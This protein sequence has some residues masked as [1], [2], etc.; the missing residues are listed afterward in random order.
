MLPRL[1]P[2]VAAT[3]IGFATITGHAGGCAVVSLADLPGQ[4]TVGQPTE[5]KFAVRQHG[6]HLLPGLRARVTAVADGRQ[7]DADAQPAEPGHYKATFTLPRAGKWNVTIHSGFGVASVL[8][9]RPIE[10]VAPGTTVAPAPLALRGLDLFVAKGCNS[11]HYHGDT[12]T[13]PVARV[14]EDLTDKRYSDGL[15]SMMLTNPAM[16]PKPDIW[17]MP[18]LKLQ[19]QEVA[20]LVAFINKPRTRP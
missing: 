10:A 20:A 6:M 9:L 2:I 3:S 15:L 17:Q 5:L 1:V 7:V 19:P 4:F 14:G 16:I 11:C 13:Q 18:D 8:N 12:R